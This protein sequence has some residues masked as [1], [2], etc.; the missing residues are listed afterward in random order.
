MS[1]SL[2]VSGTGEIQASLKTLNLTKKFGERVSVDNLNLTIYPGELYALLGDNGAGKTTTIG[3]LTTL[4]TPTSGGFYV[5]GFDGLKQSNKIRGL[6]GVVSQDVSVYN[7]LTVYENLRFLAELYGINGALIDERI[8]QL[9]S[10][11]SLLDRLNERAG[12]LSGGM[13]RRLSIACAM[14]NSPKVLFMDEPTVGLDPAARREIWAS[15]K[16]LKKLGVTILLTTHYLEEAELLADRIG[17]IRAGKLTAE[18]T[19]H[20][21]AE[22]IAGMRGLSIKLLDSVKVE[23]SCTNLAGQVERLKSKFKAG[24]NIQVR[25]DNLR[26]TIYLSQPEDVTQFEYLHTVF[27]WLKEEDL[28]FSKFASGEP[29]LEDVFLAVSRQ[30]LT[31]V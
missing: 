31:N 12:N 6:F 29:N 13:Q 8:R 26:N 1:A 10:G 5:C 25:F 11:T 14:V 9:L 27:D 21:L 24:Q 2:S 30:D 16:E 19:V 7:E 15:L 23:E 22:R 17:I 4:L 20:E 28:P 3:M 18:G